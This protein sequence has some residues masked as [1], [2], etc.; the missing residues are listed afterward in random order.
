MIITTPQMRTP[1]HREA[2]GLALGHT[3]K[4]WQGQRLDSTMIWGSR[5]ATL[6]ERGRLHLPPSQCYALGTPVLASPAQAVHPEVFS[7]AAAGG[8][9][10]PGAR[11]L[12]VQMGKHNVGRI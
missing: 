12:S 7:G 5:N 2:K 4:E 6:P 9:R 8:S 10:E 1:R 11:I 3:A